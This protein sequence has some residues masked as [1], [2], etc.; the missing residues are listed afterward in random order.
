MELMWESVD[1]WGARLGCKVIKR[2]KLTK[3]TESCK[4]FSHFLVVNTLSQPIG[5]LLKG[6]LA[7]INK[8]LNQKNQNNQPRNQNN[9]PKILILVSM[10]TI[11]QKNTNTA[12]EKKEKNNF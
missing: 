2:K 6:L 12:L 3:L 1:S 4:F 8:L 9:Q 5:S 7:S 11:L 10:Y